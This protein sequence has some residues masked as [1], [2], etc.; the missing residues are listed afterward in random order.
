[1]TPSTLRI[2][3]AAALD[4]SSPQHPGNLDL[5]LYTLKTSILENQHSI[6]PTPKLANMFSLALQLILAALAFAAPISDDIV[7]IQADAVRLPD[8]RCSSKHTA[9]TSTSG[10]MAPEAA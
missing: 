9:N 7:T 3:A 1:M 6:N 5:D 10:N 4:S 2:P 8:P